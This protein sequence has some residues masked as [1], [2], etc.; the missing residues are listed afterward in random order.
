[1]I[2]IALINNKGGVAKTTS[3]AS[4]GAYMSYI[5]KKVLMIDSDPQANLTAH[6]NFKK[7]EQTIYTAFKDFKE[8]PENAKLPLLKINDCLYLVPSE[9]DF[10]RIRENV[11]NYA[12]PNRILQRLLMP[13]KE[14]FDVCLIDL[15]PAKDVYA[16]N[17]L[18]A[19]DGVLIPIQA[20]K[21]SLDGVN[22]L[23][24]FL[25]KLKKEGFLNFEII[26]SF[27]SMYDERKSIS[28][29]VKDVVA[30]FFKEKMFSTVIRINTDIEKAQANGEDIF[31]F[32]KNS[33]SAADYGKLTEE[34]MKRINLN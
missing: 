23:V 15:P 25:M 34:L 1:M 10:E 29:A 4:I 30:E 12:E 14:H 3:T 26:G 7:E 5:G 11:F 24:S 20:S 18:F 21:F 2:T 13:F 9:P 16:K 19:C 28:T 17:A 27:L 6:F 8:D 33:N 22:S 32:A 31:M